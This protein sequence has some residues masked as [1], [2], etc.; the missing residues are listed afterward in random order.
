LVKHEAQRCKRVEKNL[1]Q[2]IKTASK[3]STK[4][5]ICNI[6]LAVISSDLTTHAARPP[7]FPF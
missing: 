4:I 2:L 3:N 1:P 5:F 6:F 7:P